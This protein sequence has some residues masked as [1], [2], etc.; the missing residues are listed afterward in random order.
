MNDRRRLVEGPKPVHHISLWLLGLAIAAL[1]ACVVLDGWRTTAGMP[2]EVR[3]MLALEDGRAIV[4]HDTRRTTTRS[5]LRLVD[6]RDP[7]RETSWQISIPSYRGSAYGERWITA[8]S[9]L[10]TVR[11]VSEQSPRV[12]AYDLSDGRRRWSAEHLPEL[13]GLSGGGRGSTATHLGSLSGQGQLIE[14]YT[15]APRWTK[16]VASD[17]GSGRVRWRRELGSG[18]VHPVWLRRDHLIAAERGIRTNT[19]RIIDRA[20]GD[21]VRELPFRDD[22]CVTAQ[23]VLTDDD[24]GISRLELDTLEPHRIP[25][26]LGA[27]AGPIR[28]AGLCGHYEDTLILGVTLGYGSYERDGRQAQSPTSAVVALDQRTLELRW[29]LDLR[30]EFPLEAGSRARMSFPD[31]IPFSGELTRYVPVQLSR[32][33]GDEELVHVVAMI[34]MEAG[35]LVWTSPSNDELLHAYLIRHR[36][37]H[38]LVYGRGRSTLAIFDGATGELGRAALLPAFRQVWPHHFAGDDLWIAWG[39]AA[40]PLDA[41]TLE[42]PWREGE[43]RLPN[44]MPQMLELL[45]LEP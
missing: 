38:Y 21:V 2:G 29:R 14:L 33:S 18:Y 25:L 26:D 4:V 20:T 28:L 10:V 43:G 32:S 9:E 19:L 12:T 16:A 37:H 39:D 23:T 8:D 36:Q 17:L 42:P 41:I 15:D 34:D 30:Y 3:E 35:A 24:D 27:E 22:P 44:A 13:H 5:V 45:G 31:H 1:V 7:Q 11:T 40:W 6:S